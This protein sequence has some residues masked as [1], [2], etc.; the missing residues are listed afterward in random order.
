MNFGGSSS[1]IAGITVTVRP[2]T[3]STS[4]TC[5]ASGSSA[6]LL[7]VVRPVEVWN[8]AGRNEECSGAACAPASASAEVSFPTQPRRRAR[9]TSASPPKT[10]QKMPS[11]ANVKPMLSAA[12][13]CGIASA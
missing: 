5:Q 3:A 4:A 11:V 6:M 9:L 10:A 13:H 2:Y 7:T 8:A 12:S 1:R